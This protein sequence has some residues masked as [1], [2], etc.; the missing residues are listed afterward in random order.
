[1]TLHP[2]NLDGGDVFGAFRA[3]QLAREVD[4][5]AILLLNDLWMLHG[6]MRTL[7]QLSETTAM[8]AY[9]PIDG[10]IVSTGVLEP[11][12]PITRFVAATEFGRGQLAGCLAELGRPANVAVIA[13]GVDTETFHP[14]AEG[15]AALRRRLFPDEPDWQRGFVVLNAN[16]PHERKRIDLT[17]AGFARFAAGKPP[18]VKLWLHH[19]H[20][21]AEERE[22]IVALAADHGI[23]RRLRL[24]ELDAGPLSDADLN[25]IYNAC[26]VGVN[27]AMGEGWGLISFE[28]AATRAAQ[29][30]PGSSACADLWAGAAEIVPATDTGVPR[31]SM[32]AMSTVTADGVAAAL[33]R[34]YADR[35]HLQELA[36]AAYRNATDPRYRWRAVTAQWNELLAEM[37]RC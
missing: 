28:H 3:V 15:R 21:D 30:V 12:H 13:H 11:L 9:V 20:M 17:I 37:I 32:L 14:L 31:F 19:A 6:Y 16:R 23:T 36:I 10:R 33:E 7:A 34:L 35:D 24:S 2:T 29:I 18:T 1:M 26:E 8:V 25:A 22:R 5:K 27:S 4:A